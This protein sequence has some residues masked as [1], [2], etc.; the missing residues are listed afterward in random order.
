MYNGNVDHERQVEQQDDKKNLKK[1]VEEMIKE[2]QVFT[3][4]RMLPPGKVDYY[5]S[6]NDRRVR[7]RMK[8]P[9]NPNHSSIKVPKLNY[10]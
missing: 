8:K 5:F 6:I 7:T 2:K 10:I 3:T 4:R 9:A 1:H